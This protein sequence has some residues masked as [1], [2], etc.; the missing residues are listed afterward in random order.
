MV[1]T[2]ARIDRILECVALK[3]SKRLADD[4][5]VGKKGDE[6]LMLPVRVMT[7]NK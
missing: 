6:M 7:L 2:V 1:H 4:I 3:F 5:V